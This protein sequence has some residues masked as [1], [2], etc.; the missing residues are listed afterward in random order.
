MR[1]ITK[2]AIEAFLNGDSFSRSNTKVEIELDKE[3]VL[4]LFTHPIAT[5]LPNG[6]I[7]V[8]N[9]GYPTVTTKERLNGIP[10]VSIQQ[11]KGQW[12]LNGSPW[13]GAWI[14]VR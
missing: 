12:F 8:T 3:V 9:A 13:D 4:S 6:E 11:R 5:K 10:G 14:H 2:D 1:K 7:L